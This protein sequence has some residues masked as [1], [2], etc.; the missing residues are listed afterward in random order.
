MRLL[1]TTL[2]AVALIMSPL[3]G[4]QVTVTAQDIGAWA[5][6]AVALLAAVSV[7]ANGALIRA[8]QKAANAA[9][10][11][12]ELAKQTA[13]AASEQTGIAK[14]AAATAAEQARAASV[15]ADAALAQTRLAYPMLTVDLDG[16][17]IAAGQVTLVGNITVISGSMA[18]THVE[19]WVN[20]HGSIYRSGD[21]PLMSLGNVYQFEAT[22]DPA[23]ESDPL[24]VALQEHGGAGIWIGLRWMEPDGSHARLEFPVRHDKVMGPRRL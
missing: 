16:N 1:A 6:V 10:Y 15:T 21:F 8:T 2:V 4:F 3:S 13:D 24:V 9:S 18:A 5:T 11:Q 22:V 7:V 14:Q 12:A 17:T 23:P 19:L 20:N